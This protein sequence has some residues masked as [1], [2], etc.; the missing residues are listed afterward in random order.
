MRF[1]PCENELSGKELQDAAQLAKNG[2]VI[3]EACASTGMS[4]GGR[5]KHAKIYSINMLI[6]MRFFPCENEFSEKP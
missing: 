2:D 5:E 1:H 6:R 3:A 4:S